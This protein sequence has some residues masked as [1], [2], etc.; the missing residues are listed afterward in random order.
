[1]PGLRGAVVAECDLA[2]AD[3]GRLVGLGVDE[4]ALGLTEWHGLAH[5][6][7]RRCHVVA[8]LDRECAKCMKFELQS[9]SKVWRLGCVILHSGSLKAHAA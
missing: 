2:G 3:V 1:M 5:A 7:A 9:L 8:L 4:A 6:E